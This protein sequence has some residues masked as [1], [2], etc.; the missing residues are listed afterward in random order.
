MSLLV[1][2]SIA[3]DSIFTPF[4]ET[5]DAL[6]GS[7]VYFSVAG[8]L[9]HPV[10]VVGVVGKRLSRRRARAARRPRHRLVRRRAGRR[11][12][13]PLEGQV[14]L[15]P[16][17]PRDAGDPARRVRRLPAQAARTPSGRPSS[18]SSATSIPSSS[19][20]CWSRC[21]AR[22][23][24]VR[25]DE[26]LDPEQEGRRCS[27]CSR[28]VDVLMVND[29]EARELSGDWNIHRAGRWILA[30]G[31]KRVV[32]KQGEHGALLIEPDAHLLRPG[33]SAGERVRSHRRGRRVRRR[34]HGLPRPHRIGVRGQHPPG[35]GRTAPPWAPTRS[36]SSASGAST[37]HAGRRGA[38]GA[39]LPGSHPREPGRGAR[40]TSATGEYAAAGVDLDSAEAAKA[41]IGEL[42]AG[43]RTR[44]LG[45][46]GRAPS[47]EWCACPPACGSRRWCSAP[48][49]SA[50]RCS[51]RSQAGR[52]DTVGEDLVNHSVND[53]LVHGAHADRV[54]GLH[55][56]ARGS[57]SSR[58]PASSRASPA[59]AGPTA[60]RWPAARP[61]RCPGL[62]QP[63]TY[64]LAGT[65]VGVVE[66]DR[67]HPRRRHRPG[68]RAP[69]LRLHRTAHQ[70]LHAGPA[71]RLRPDAA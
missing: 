71:H 47:A 29:S 15:R 23:G 36:S 69:G 3:L 4:G 33:L 60:W 64:D 17:E 2:G 16:A 42:V 31:P 48:M 65:I 34:V 67:A 22:A 49:A 9:L 24:R 25:H 43:T 1:V 66:E 50:P 14:L 61:R 58:S 27:S 32:I 45:G 57:A 53:I 13:L 46:Q 6:G 40:V 8:S 20:A 12:E 10:Q 37:G 28:R 55:R 30:H 11:R 38:A 62:Y 51:W 26:L 21:A 39:R 7:A 18:S 35:H 59:A 19:S 41:R 44:A 54:H 56:R 68:R 70:R 63:G 5:A 52:F